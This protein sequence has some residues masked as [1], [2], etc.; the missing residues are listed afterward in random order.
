MYA[1]QTES[2]CDSDRLLRAHLDNAEHPLIRFPNASIAVC[3]LN[4]LGQIE[5]YRTPLRP[6]ALV[7][8]DDYVAI[9]STEDILR[10]SLGKVAVSK[11]S[12]NTVYKIENGKLDDSLSYYD[13]RTDL[14]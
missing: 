3:K 1:L 12:I 10:R 5:A 13:G 6:L 11:A 14:Q 9:A 8:G 7:H 2:K 4:D